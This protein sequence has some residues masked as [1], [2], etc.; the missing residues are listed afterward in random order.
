MATARTATPATANRERR[1]LSIKTMIRSI[2]HSLRKSLAAALVC[3]AAATAPSLA[4]AGTFDCGSDIVP[5]IRVVDINRLHDEAEEWCGWATHDSCP[6]A[7]LAGPPAPIAFGEQASSAERTEL[8]PTPLQPADAPAEHVHRE[9]VEIDAVAEKVDP[10]SD[11]S[12][13]DLPL[14]VQPIPLETLAKLTAGGVP[15]RTWS[16]PMAMVGP[17]LTRPLSNIDRL[18]AF[19]H[20][21]IETAASLAARSPKAD[22]K[23]NLEADIETLAAAEPIDAVTNEMEIAAALLADEH[24]EHQASTEV[25]ET[26]PPTLSVAQ[27]DPL[28]GGSAVVATIDEE[29]RP[30]DLSHNDLTIW[31]SIASDFQP[32]CVRACGDGQD[33]LAFVPTP[34]PDPLPNGDPMYASASNET[35]DVTELIDTVETELARVLAEVQTESEWQLAEQSEGVVPSEDVATQASLVSETDSDATSHVDAALQASA[36]CLLDEWLYRAEPWTEVSWTLT[37]ANL[38]PHMASGFQTI[39]R[40][41]STAISSIIAAVPTRPSEMP[42]VAAADADETDIR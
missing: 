27:I 26:H 8:A 34:T 16:G 5:I 9:W 38:R 24:F 14:Q 1:L 10:L 11:R 36:D 25:A 3:A 30:Y 15:V 19:W 28:T 21:S 20:R 23:A 39:E 35:I 22:S 4:T 37:H 6:A 29:Y 17:F 33:L 2:R 12:L 40:L 31:P 18:Q 13:D 7:V 41:R 42:Q 32:F